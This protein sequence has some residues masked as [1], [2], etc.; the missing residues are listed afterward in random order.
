[1]GY[2]FAELGNF[3][4]SNPYL[5]TLPIGSFLIFLGLERKKIHELLLR[6]NSR[7]FRK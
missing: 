7:F 5:Y 4:I 2:S 3:I 6:F 1:M